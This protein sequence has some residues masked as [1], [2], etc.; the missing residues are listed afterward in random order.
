MS[1]VPRHYIC[2]E[3][4]VWISCALKQACIIFT[5]RVYLSALAPTTPA[6]YIHPHVTMQPVQTTRNE[7]NRTQ[8]FVLGPF[9]WHLPSDHSALCHWASRVD[10]PRH[11]DDHS[12]FFTVAHG[13]PP[14]VVAYIIICG[15]MVLP[16]VEVLS[17][18]L[19]ISHL[20]PRRERLLM[21]SLCPNLK[22]HFWAIRSSPAH[23]HF[24]SLQ[25]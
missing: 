8:A 9:S 2:G 11:C 21:T 20:D 12:N 23:N 7:P 10:D 14:T 17:P 5:E 6:S 13:T 25:I 15:S 24:I 16:T 4:K 18:C 1:W 19:L 22:C 3:E